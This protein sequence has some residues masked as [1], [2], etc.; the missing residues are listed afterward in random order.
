MSLKGSTDVSSPK[1]GTVPRRR[2]SLHTLPGFV[3]MSVL[4]GIGHRFSPWRMVVVSL[5]APLSFDGW[6]DSNLAGY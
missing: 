6:A 2:S 4:E 3:L 5:V 1:L